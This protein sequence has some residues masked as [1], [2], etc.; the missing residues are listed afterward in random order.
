MATKKRKTKFWQSNK[1]RTGNHYSSYWLGKYNPDNYRSIFDENQNEPAKK[2]KK[3]DIFRLLEA[4]QAISNF[5]RILTGRN[6]IAIEFS[7]SKDAGVNYTDGKTIVLSTNLEGDDFDTA[8]GLALHEA[9]H[10]VYT[11]FETMK[12]NVIIS[13]NVTNDYKHIKNIWNCIEDFYIDSMTYKT[14]PGYRGYYKSL[15]NEYFGSDDI[16]KGFTSTKYAEV[17]WDSY[18][19]HL[20]NIRN[21]ARNLNALPC[22]KEIWNRLNLSNI[23]LLSTTQS[24]WDLAFEI[25]NLINSVIQSQPESKNSTELGGGD[26][27][28]KD[29]N[30]QSLPFNGN[31]ENEDSDGDA[32]DGPDLKEISKSMSQRLDKMLQKQLD[33][34]DGNPKKNSITNEDSKSLKHL[35]DTDSEIRVVGNTPDSSGNVINTNGIRV[36]V[37]RN[38]TPQMVQSGNLREYSIYPV[39]TGWYQERYNALVERGIL[40]GRKLA[41]RIQLRNEER[42]TKTTRLKNGVIDRRLLNELAFDNFQIFNKINIKTYKPIH[43]HVSID[44]SGSMNG[45]RYENSLE[46]ASCLAS[47]SMLIKNLHVVVTLRGTTGGEGLPFLC[48][49]FDSKKHNFSQIRDVFPY[50]HAGGSTPEG[51][52]FEAIEKEIKRDALNNDSY[53]INLCDGAP[54]C[55]IRTTN[56]YGQ[57]VWGNYAGATAYRHCRAQ[58]LKMEKHGVTYLTYFFGREEY[59]RE[60]KECY[61]NRVVFLDSPSQIEM[62]ATTINSKLIETLY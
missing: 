62:V 33:Y 17:N 28:E 43:I 60:V 12:E 9:S 61:A 11:D 10:I 26:S 4:R 36:L 21:P 1:N 13:Q 22:L 23:Q 54:A 52:C 39:S 7:P 57:S 53:F 49:I 44:A 51:L 2:K 16:L 18:M 59:G 47:A 27:E 24:R 29:E 41:K 50:T 19:F 5:V 37:I 58:M 20:C 38:V 14:A 35:R 42:V 30:Q 6:D 56:S 15:Y 34:F 3:Y 46:L 32:T 8:V 40:N 31:D 25:Y 55:S 45:D 48:Y